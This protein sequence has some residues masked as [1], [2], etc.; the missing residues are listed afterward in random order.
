MTA[1]AH[2]GSVSIAVFQGFPPRAVKLTDT[3]PIDGTPVPPVRTAAGRR[4]V[5]LV[6]GM[7]V[8]RPGT[9]TLDGI[10]VRYRQGHTTRE[11]VLPARLAVCSWPAGAKV[12]SS[13]KAPA[14]WR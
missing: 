13:C 7:Q 5:E 2:R 11:T 9:Y 12:T 3:R 8:P 4:G 10:R 1:G 14:R 6:F